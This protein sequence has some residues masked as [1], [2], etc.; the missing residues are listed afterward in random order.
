MWKE[1]HYI[2]ERYYTEKHNF[3]EAHYEEAYGGIFSRWSV[4]PHLCHFFEQWG[5]VDKDT[6]KCH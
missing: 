2:C 5:T 1:K 3:E 4:T 6:L